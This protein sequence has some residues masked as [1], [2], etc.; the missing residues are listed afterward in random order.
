ME[1]EQ[2]KKRV[3]F[4]NTLM[5][6]L[7]IFSSYFFNFITIPWQ[8]RVL[9]PEYFGRLGFAMAMMAYF[10]LF[11]D[12]GFI[13]SATEEVARH[14]DDRHQLSRIMTAVN[15]S[16]FLLS[17]AGLVLLLLACW[18]A[19]RL[20]SEIRLYLFYYASVVSAAFIPDF[21]Y[22]G[23][24]RMKTITLFTVLVQVIFLSLIFLF[25][26][27][28]E[29]YLLVPL[30]TTLGNLAALAGVYYHAQKNE[31]VSHVRVEWS[32]VR[33][34]LSKSSQ[35]FLSRIAITVYSATNTF[36]VGL[37]NP[38]GSPVVGLFSSA[39]RL[40]N[41]ARRGFTPIAD[42][43]YPYMVRNRDYRMVFRILVLLFPPVLAGCLLLG[44]RAE[45]FCAFLLGAKFRDAG[46][47][48]RYLLPIVVFTPA[49][50]TL[51]FPVLTPMGLARH[52]N[53]STIVGSCFHI[54]GLAAMILTGHFGVRNLCLLT[55]ATE[56]L[57]LFHRS[58]VIFLHR[59][60]LKPEY[61]DKTE[62]QPE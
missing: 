39:D 20:S 56:G 10:R 15:I 17:T 34:T 30:F 45:D 13:L 42:S 60:R 9:G 29:D 12:F 22:R 32:L 35:F 18:L 25:L 49:A 47:I 37:L 31:G 54:A 3:L 59:E 57:V 61:T 53:L 7:L 8:T 44:F 40:I 27:R 24:E 41:T 48:V 6:Y 14:R 46:A 1:Q 33:Q 58:L 38:L 50:Y 16:K 5:L 43:L 2:E 11:I 21:L 23:L 26:K 36:L 28:P 51:G 52:A 55:L 4:Q 62:T 19:P